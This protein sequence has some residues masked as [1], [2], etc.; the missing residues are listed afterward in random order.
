MK[1]HGTFLRSSVARRIFAL[2]L[3]SALI[4]SA[5]VAF[6]SIRQVDQLLL[7]QSRAELAKLSKANSMALYERLLLVEDLLQQLAPDLTGDADRRSDPSIRAKGKIVSL[8]LI[9][10]DATTQTLFGATT[11]I[12]YAPS[13]DERH[14]LAEGKTLL[15]SVNEPRSETRVFMMRARGKNEPRTRLSA[16]GTRS[17][18]PVG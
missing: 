8:A 13:A 15:F 5:G 7:Q 6:L 18:L 11:T 17:T 12:R 1:L 14:H 16:R 2:F 9:R 10:S 3:L 4:P